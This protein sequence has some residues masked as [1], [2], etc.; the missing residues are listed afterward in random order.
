MMNTKRIFEYSLVVLVV[1][2]LLA[3]FG[4]YIEKTNQQLAGAK[5]T[6]AAH[7]MR[8]SMTLVYVHCQVNGVLECGPSMR[9][10]VSNQEGLRIRTEKGYPAPSADGIV[11]AAGLKSG[12]YAIR[13]IQDGLVITMMDQA[14][15]VRCAITYQLPERSSTQ[16]TLDLVVDGC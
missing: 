16:A 4:H 2:L 14:Q 5:L 15:N 8:M 9:G 12:V 13:Y 7:A 10:W 11:V 3:V 6:T 1:M